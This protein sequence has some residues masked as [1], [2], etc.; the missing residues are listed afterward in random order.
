PF[1]PFFPLGSA[2]DAR[3]PVLEHPAVRA[4]AQRLSALPSQV[5]IAWLLA[6]APNTLLIPG[7]SSLQHLEENLAAADLVLDDE[8]LASLDQASG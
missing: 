8:A 1:V 2:F 4:T 6:L 3:K 7:T 5:A